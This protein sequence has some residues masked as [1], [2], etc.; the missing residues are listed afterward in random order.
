[1]HLLAPDIL[2]EA[3]GLSV[4]LCTVG[5]AAGLLL[6]VFGWWGH[7]FWVVLTATLAAGVLGLYAGPD[8][9]MQRLVA[10]LLLAVAAG[11]LALSLIRVV[12]FAAGGLAAWLAAR[13]LL[14]GWDDAQGLLIGLLAGGLVGL[15]LFRVWMM[16]LTSLAGTLLMGYSG[17]CL[18]DR[19][20]KLDAPAWAEQHVVLLDVVCGAAALLGLALQFFLDRRLRRRPLEEEEPPLPQPRSEPRPRRAAVWDWLPGGHRRAG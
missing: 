10:G 18:A 6:W 14:P 15:L 13:A 4:A 3:Q 12:A 9:G 7:R 11:A 17:L 16:A 20:G 2:T 19:L 1:M 5:L 8:L